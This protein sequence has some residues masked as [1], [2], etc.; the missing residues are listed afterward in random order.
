MILFMLWLAYAIGVKS[1]FMN[2]RVMKY[3]G[4][5]SMEM[6]LAQM[7]VFRVIEKAGLLYKFGGGWLSFIVVMILEISL[8]VVGIEVWKW[9][10]RRIRTI[11]MRE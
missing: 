6:Y 2:N 3:L 8:L 9:A 7:V 11:R 10:E 1:W 4:G 5:I